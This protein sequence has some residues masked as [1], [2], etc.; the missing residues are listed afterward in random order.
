MPYAID[1]SV[2]GMSRLKSGVTDK[3][4]SASNTTRVMTGSDGRSH[5]IKFR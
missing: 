5:R 3:M 2:A 1:G 4:V